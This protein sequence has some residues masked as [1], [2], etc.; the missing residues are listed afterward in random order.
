MESWA[1][2][3]SILV[4]H[5]RFVIITIN[6][7][8]PLQCQTPT[9]AAGQRHRAVMFAPRARALHS[10]SC[11]SSCT[12]PARHSSAILR[13]RT[14][15]SHG[16][17]CLLPPSSCEELQDSHPPWAVRCRSALRSASAPAILRR[18]QLLAQLCLESRALLKSRGE[19]ALFVSRVKLGQ[20]MAKTS[21]HTAVPTPVK[22]LK[23]STSAA[24]AAPVGHQKMLTAWATQV[25]EIKWRQ[26]KMHHTY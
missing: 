9:R 5:A 14:A 12:P 7:R 23:Y 24:C 26:I 8:S 1:H 11:S 21:Q 15:R 19:K 2:Y 10:S 18:G 20:Q 3:C 13:S 6:Q 22:P 25:S 16:E 4:S 17:L